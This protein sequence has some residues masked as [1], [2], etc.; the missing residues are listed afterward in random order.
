MSHNVY[1]IIIDDVLSFDLCLFVVQILLTH[2]HKL[3]RWYSPWRI[4]LKIRNCRV[5]RCASIVIDEMIE[6]IKYL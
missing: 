4:A 5:L 3:S 1:K 6:H 2:Y